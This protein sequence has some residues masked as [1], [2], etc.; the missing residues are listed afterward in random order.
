MQG[1]QAIARR[2]GR[3]EEGWAATR[4]QMVK[5]LVRGRKGN[6]SHDATVHHPPTLPKLTAPLPHRPI[7]PLPHPITP[8]SHKTHH[9]TKLPSVIRPCCYSALATCVDSSLPAATHL[10]RRPPPPSGSAVMK[11]APHHT[12]DHNNRCGG[13]GIPRLRRARACMYTSR[14]AFFPSVSLSFPRMTMLRAVRASL[15]RA[16]SSSSASDEDSS[17]AV[18][19]CDNRA[20]HCQVESGSG[21]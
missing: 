11:Q 14:N 15:I 16:A 20:A 10:A 1:G 13:G 18:S 19:L 12:A 21:K 6:A 17:T 3:C 5:N 9:P 8:P 7:A 4:D 2:D